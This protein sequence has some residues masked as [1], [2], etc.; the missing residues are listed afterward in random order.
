MASGGTRGAMTVNE[1]ATTGGV[2]APSLQIVENAAQDRF[3]LWMDGE[4]VGIIGYAIE[5]GDCMPGKA[6]AGCVVALMH[7]VVMEEYWHRGLAAMLVRH[8][9]DTARERGWSVRPVCTYVQAFLTKHP[10]YAPLTAA[11]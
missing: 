6:G 7:T 8:T 10:E 11:S 1:S 9:L 5:G 4:L 2:G 3:E